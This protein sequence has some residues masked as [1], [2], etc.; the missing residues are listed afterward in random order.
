MLSR[1]RVCSF[2]SSGPE[3]VL[4]MI[5]GKQ[6]HQ[7]H[8]DLPAGIFRSNHQRHSIGIFM[9]RHKNSIAITCTEVTSDADTASEHFRLILQSQPDSVVACCG[10]IWYLC[11]STQLHPSTASRCFN[12]FNLLEQ[13]RCQRIRLRVVIAVSVIH[14]HLIIFPGYCNEPKAKS[15][16]K[17]DI[18]YQDRC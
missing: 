11:V 14:N 10:K 3:A 6:T 9:K 2:N 16:G 17:V 8:P 5:L 12:K 4:V 18:Y 1:R 7:F 15:L 13:W